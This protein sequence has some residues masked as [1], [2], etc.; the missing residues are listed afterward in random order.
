K[1]NEIKEKL[2]VREN[3]LT[4]EEKEEFKNVPKKLIIKQKDSFFLVDLENKSIADGVK[5]TKDEYKLFREED[6]IGIR[7]ISLIFLI[8]ISFAFL[9]NYAQIYILNYTSQKIIYN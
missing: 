5:L 6:R 9:F 1:D 2:Y 3:N 4:V 7:N 8:I